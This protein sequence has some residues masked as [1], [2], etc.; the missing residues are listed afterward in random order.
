M[1]ETAR[2]NC[3]FVSLCCQNAAY[4]IVTSSSGLIWWRGVVIKNP[5]PHLRPPLVRTGLVASRK[6]PAP[7]PATR[8]SL[9]VASWT[10]SDPSNRDY[11]VRHLPRGQYELPICA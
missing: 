1:T 7:M 5:D 3:D 2:E 11:S 8:M 9:I 10:H 6:P 4:I